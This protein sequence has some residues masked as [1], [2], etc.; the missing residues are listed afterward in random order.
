M[1][2]VAWASVM[3]ARVACD[4]RSMGG[5]AWASVLGENDCTQVACPCPGAAVL[6]DEVYSLNPHTSRGVLHFVRPPMPNEL[7]ALARRLSER[8]VSM[9]RHRGLA[10]APRHDSNESPTLGAARNGFHTAALSRGRI[11]SLREFEALA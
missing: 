4:V 9:L 5:V 2:G 11:A 8:V 7:E 1:W 3:C 6:I 10:H